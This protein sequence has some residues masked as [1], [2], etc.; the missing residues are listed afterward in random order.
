MHSY[1]DTVAYITNL[2]GGEI[3]LK[4]DRVRQALALFDNPQN[5]Y[6]S[7]HI[8]GTNGKGSTAAMVHQILS[9]QGYR[10]GLYTSPHLVSFTERIRVADEEIN[11]DEVVELAAL[12]R[13]RLEGQGLELTFFEFVTVMGL[14]YFAEKKI[15]VAVV[16]VGLGGRL[17][18]TNVVLPVSSLITT[19]SRDHEAYLGNDLLSIAREKGGIIKQGVPLVCGRLSEAVR[20][21]YQEL[22]ATRQ[23]PAYFFGEHF[24]VVVKGEQRFDYHGLQ[25]SFKD[26]QLALPGSFQRNNAAVA[27]AALEVGGQHFPVTEAAVRKGLEKVIWPAR[28]EVVRQQ[29]QVILDGA[30]NGEGVMTLV[31]EIEALRKNRRIK[32]LFGA[33]QDKDWRLMLGHLCAI[34]DEVVLTRVPMARSAEPAV[35]ASAIPEGIPY[36]IIENPRQALEFL[37]RRA[38]RDD[39][40]LVT[41]SLYLMGEVRPFFTMEKNVELPLADTRV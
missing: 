23:A 14:V 1:R 24:G 4:L 21:L 6:L 19:I 36:H 22:A 11:A 38:D 27:L 37:L 7:F 41:G 12:I 34:A 30:H 5:R 26:L 15:T 20:A 35:L 32:L 8:A 17:D 28:M 31:A 13:Q 3:D 33:L 16:E 40:M 2:R 25:W 18:A 39:M 9:C 10:A 29:P